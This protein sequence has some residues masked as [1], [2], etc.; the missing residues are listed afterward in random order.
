MID[1]IRS[2]EADLAYR[3]VAGSRLSDDLDAIE[4]GEQGRKP[5]PYDR[6]VVGQQDPN[7]RRVWRLG[8][9]HVSIM[10]RMRRSVWGR[11]PTGAGT[12]PGPIAND[13]GHSL[14]RWA[15]AGS[16]RMRDGIR[17]PNGGP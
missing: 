15:G 10:K 4:R 6:V 3:L 11:G 17:T 2:A 7:G 1:H 8:R 12:F 9:R 16:E 14:R 5:A 13:S